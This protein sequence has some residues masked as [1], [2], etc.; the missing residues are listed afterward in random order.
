MLY[1]PYWSQ[2]EERLARAE[3]K[4]KEDSEKLARQREKEAAE[5]AKEE[6][7]EL[8]RK[9]A[10][11]SL[12]FQRLTKFSIFWWRVAV[13]VRKNPKKRALWFD[14]FHLPV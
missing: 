3:K 9:L 2:D 7:D 14:T 12:V 8:Q 4:K 10:T 6:N 5:K 11:V 1:F 13:G